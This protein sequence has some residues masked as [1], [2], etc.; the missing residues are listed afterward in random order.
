M[1]VVTGELKMSGLC[2]FLLLF[3]IVLLMGGVGPKMGVLSN[4]VRQR[5]SRWIN[6][7]AN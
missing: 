5:E 3:F 1:E 6:M 7:V 2:E 4:R